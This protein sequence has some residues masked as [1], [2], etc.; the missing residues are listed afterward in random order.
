MSEQNQEVNKDAIQIEK[1][2]TAPV[3][4]TLYGWSSFISFSVN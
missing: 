4:G 2:D 1:F 3:E